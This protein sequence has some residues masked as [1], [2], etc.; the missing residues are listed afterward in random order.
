M[1]ACPRAWAITYATLSGHLNPSKAPPSTPPRTFDDL[2]TRT[3]R[4]TWLKRLADQYQRKIWSI[5]YGKRTLECAVDDAMDL[6]NMSVPHLHLEMGKVRSNKQLR[7]LEQCQTLRPLFTGQPR[8]WAYFDRRTSANIGGVEVY[9]APDVAI[10]HQHQWTLVRL[11]FRSSRRSLLGQ[12]LEHLLMVHWAMNQPGFP[13]NFDA[14][15]V[16]VVRWQ[17]RAWQE[18]TVQVS[19]E[20]LEQSLGLMNHDVQEMTWLQRWATADPSLNSL[21]L[22]TH[23]E[24]CQSC[25]HRPDC[26]AKDGLNSAKRAQETNVLSPN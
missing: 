8:R 10:F 18:H 26:P 5:P 4:A 25:R 12:Q 19:N 1:N 24:Q 3:M 23:H 2:L 20:L 13:Q 21:P 16:R 15:R 11:Q 7:S 6:V 22:A 14:Y 17:G 9:A